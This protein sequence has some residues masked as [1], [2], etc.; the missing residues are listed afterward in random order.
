MAEL[1]PLAQLIGPQGPP[2]YNATDAA[3]DLATLEAY[4]REIAG[5][6][7][8]ATALY[9]VVAAKAA[10]QQAIDKKDAEKRKLGAG[11]AGVEYADATETV[12]TWA[13]LSGVTPVANA[14]VSGNKHYANNAAS[15][16]GWIKNISGLPVTGKW[17]V[18][19]V[20][21]HKA[22][23]SPISFFGLNCKAPGTAL[24]SAD[25]DTVAIGITSGN[26]RYMSLG[27]NLTAVNGLNAGALGSNP[28]VDTT[29]LISI[30]ADE[31]DISFTM[32]NIAN[33]ADFVYYSFERA[34]LAAIPKVIGN[35]SCYLTDVRGVAGSAFGPFVLQ[36]NSQQPPRTKVVSSQTIVGSREVP[37]RRSSGVT[38][39]PQMQT[40]AVP[41]NYDPRKPT[42]LVLWAHQSVTGES[43]D[44][45]EEPRVQPV[46]TALLNAGYAIAGVN[47]IDYPGNSFGNQRG[48]D[49]LFKMYKYM[50]ENFNIGPLFFYGA[51]M[52]GLDMANA[53]FRRQFPTPAAA[54]CVGGA[55][56]IG[57][58][59]DLGSPFQASIEAAYSA[60]GRPD[61]LTK[62][63]GYDP[64]RNAG[65]MFRAVP[66]RFY[67]SAGDPYQP[68][69]QQNAFKAVIQN[70]A[71]E[72]SVIL[73]TGGHLDPSQYQPTDVLD[74]FERYRV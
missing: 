40:F 17:R 33:L 65:R 14:Q 7:V 51:S 41:K 19:T 61:L 23:G 20:L 27:A 57:H 73:G 10:A 12:E 58:V 69:A 16:G 54:A 64:I 34:S 45:W 2:G 22:G 46:T 60:S 25:P 48:Q 52:G 43:W 26:A 42:P 63:V 1:Y 30:I 50:I 35:I 13:N 4:V 67:T 24:T 8:F 62:S 70:F 6:N 9:E 38:S 71:P 39:A 68:P 28:T 49:H 47:D 37:R 18:D 15:P 56:D 3:S 74:F 31:E 44:P 21:Y 53:I 59:W 11:Q 5:S 32:A 55:F 66:W 72:S 36:Y 29:Y